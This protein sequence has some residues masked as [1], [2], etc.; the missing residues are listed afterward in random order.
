M[1]V[2]RIT[3]KPIESIRKHKNKHLIGGNRKVGRLQQSPDTSSASDVTSE[4][5]F[6]C[7]PNLEGA[8]RT[9]CSSIQQEGLTR[10]EGGRARSSV[11]M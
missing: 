1:C 10:D 8:F 11:R 9:S 2:Y 5:T 4:K 7:L 3:Q 6:R